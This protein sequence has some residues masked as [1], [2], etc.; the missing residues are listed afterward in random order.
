VP[1]VEFAA[2][3]ALAAKVS[4]RGHAKLLLNGALVIEASDIDDGGSVSERVEATRV[5]GDAEISVGANIAYLRDAVSVECE[6]A[7]IGMTDERS[8]VTLRFPDDTRRLAVVMP[9]RI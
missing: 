7:V 3:L 6:N 8:P 1:V 4:G 9:I 2:A 5:H